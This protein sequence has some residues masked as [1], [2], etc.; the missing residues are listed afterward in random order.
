MYE[1]AHLE[2][3]YSNG[4]PAGKED[5]RCSVSQFRMSCRRLADGQISCGT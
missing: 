5:N 2:D 1:A 4:R 3:R